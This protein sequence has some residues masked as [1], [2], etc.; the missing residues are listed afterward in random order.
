M[1]SKIDIEKI[2]SFEVTKSKW[3]NQYN[4]E[5]FTTCSSLNKKLFG[6][7]FNRSENC[8][9]IEDFFL[10]FK[11]Y[12]Q[13]NKLEKIMEKKFIL[14]KGIMLQNHNFPSPITRMSSDE[15]CI[16]LLRINKNYAKQFEI[17]PTDWEKLINGRIEEKV[18]EIINDLIEE[19]IEEVDAKKDS[20][21]LNTLSL[22]DLRKYAKLI[23]LKT[24]AKNKQNLINEIKNNNT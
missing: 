12:L 2:L 14:K 6:I 16:K 9:C 22:V 15:D 17:L 11:Y 21:D 24:K 19:S 20:N 7:D 10:M 13:N 8:H 18:D 4:S 3:R 5:E 23:G 1:I